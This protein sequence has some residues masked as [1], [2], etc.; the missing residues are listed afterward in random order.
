[1]R[2]FLGARLNAERPCGVM[3]ACDRTYGTYQAALT[4]IRALVDC[5]L[6]RE[7]WILFVWSMP[8]TLSQ[9]TSF[10]FPVHNV[11]ILLLSLTDLPGEKK[12]FEK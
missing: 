10:L 6:E 12:P 9:R 11:L 8:P 4:L 5:G 7:T 3:S 2:F 1:M